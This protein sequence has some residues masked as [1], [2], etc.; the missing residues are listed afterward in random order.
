MDYEKLDKIKV[1]I[2]EKEYELMVAK[3][4]EEKEY[5]LMGVSELG[6]NEGM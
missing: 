1:T 3:S 2:N 5:G 6:D 4:E